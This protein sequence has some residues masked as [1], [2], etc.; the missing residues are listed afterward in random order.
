MSLRKMP[1]GNTTF[2]SSRLWTTCLSQGL[3][4]Q[5]HNTWPSSLRIFFQPGGSCTHPDPWHPKRTIW[6]IFL[7]GQPGEH[8]HPLHLAYIYRATAYALLKIRYG[9]LVNYWCMGYEAKH[10]FFKRLSSI[11]GNYITLP[12]TL[13]KRHQHLQCYRMVCPTKFLYKD[14]KFGKGTYTWALDTNTHLLP[15]I[16]LY[17][18][19]VWLETFI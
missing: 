4:L 10:S 1:T 7:L 2:S 14:L 8:W 18:Q 16:I 12:L 5:S 19:H 11:I 3:Q 6:Y 15:T 13:A 17:T 9:P